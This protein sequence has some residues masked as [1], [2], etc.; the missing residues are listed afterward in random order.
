MF[1]V[2]DAKNFPKFDQKSF[3]SLLVRRF[4]VSNCKLNQLLR[5]KK[6]MLL[7]VDTLSERDSLI[8]NVF[9]KLKDYCR[10]KYGLEFQVSRNKFFLS[11]INISLFIEVFGYA[12]G[13][14]N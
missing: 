7:Y 12:M 2:D 5:L 14:S 9:P 6:S 8:D 11:C 1:Y 10:E 4:L 3:V 13:N